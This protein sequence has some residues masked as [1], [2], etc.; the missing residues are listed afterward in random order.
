MHSRLVKGKFKL[1]EGVY[2]AE[3]LRD[4]YQSGSFN[5][6]DLVN[7]R[8]LRGYEMRVRLRNDDTTEANL[9][10]VKINSTISQ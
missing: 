6:E 2:L 3:F 5:R 8:I 4:A 1:Q 10:I 7:G 9:R